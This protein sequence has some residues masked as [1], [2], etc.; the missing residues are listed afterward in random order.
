MDRLFDKI[1]ILHSKEIIESKHS[2]NLWRVQIIEWLRQRP[3]RSALLLLQALSLITTVLSC[4]RLSSPQEPNPSMEHHAEKSLSCRCLNFLIHLCDCRSCVSPLP[5]LVY[6][7]FVFLRS[8]P[9]CQPCL[10]MSPLPHLN[11]FLIL[12]S[13]LS[14]YHNVCDALD[15]FLTWPHHLNRAIT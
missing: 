7:L 12:L 10:C 2:G 9:A 14:L 15:L 5:S 6:H 13:C 1:I 8:R 4:G 11:L 3:P